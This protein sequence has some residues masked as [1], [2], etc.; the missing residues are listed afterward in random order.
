[1]SPP[2]VTLP[3]CLL[4][5]CKP[6]VLKRCCSLCLSHPF[7][8]SLRLLLPFSSRSLPPSLSQHARAPPP[9]SPPPLSFHHRPTSDATCARVV[10]QPYSALCRVQPL[11]GVSCK[12][13]F[14]DGNAI[15]AALQAPP[16]SLAILPSTHLPTLLPSQSSLHLFSLHCRL[17]YV[18]LSSAFFL[19]TLKK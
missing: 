1:M 10:L 17:M 14:T 2:S 6:N 12:V 11:E 13:E 3:S 19:M 7:T 9:P 8:H 15:H 16:S 18:A 5:C 4:S